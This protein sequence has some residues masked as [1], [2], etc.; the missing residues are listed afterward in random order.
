MLW[1][2]LGLIVAAAVYFFL[3]WPKDE[4]SLLEAIERIYTELDEDGKRK[5]ERFGD[6]LLAHQER[7]QRKKE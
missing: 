2:I 6:W 5:M 4:D 1:W 7:Q 3:T